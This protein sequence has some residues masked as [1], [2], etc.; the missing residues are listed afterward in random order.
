[1]TALYYKNT[2]L[3]TIVKPWIDAGEE[4]VLEEDQDS[5]HGIMRYGRGIVQTWKRDIGLKNYF[6][7]SGSSDLSPIENA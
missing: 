1:M 5:A 6:N 3:E 2:I 4:F 7:C